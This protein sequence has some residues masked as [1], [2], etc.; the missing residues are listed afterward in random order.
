MV[1]TLAER[2]RR[3][4]LLIL[5]GAMGTELD[6]RGV[7]F[8]KGAWSGP[9]VLTHPDVVREIHADYARAGAEVHIA[10]SFATS[11]HVLAL[12]G[13]DDRF[14][15]ANR[16]AVDLC[17]QGIT[18]DG[19][20]RPQWI[21]GSVSTYAE[22]SKRTALPP[23]AQLR[24]NLRDQCKVLADAGVD[25]LA[26]EMLMDIEVSVML[27][28]AAAETGLPFWAGFT[29][30]W[31]DDG[32]VMAGAGGYRGGNAV[33]LANALDAV[34][35]AAD[36]APMMMSVM[37]CELDV[38][39]AALKVVGQKWTGDIVV[40]PNSGRYL[41]PSWDFSM[42]C[43]PEAFTDAAGRWAADG[44]RI[45]GGCCGLGPVHIQA[46]AAEFSPA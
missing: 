36:G 39:A 14:D 45:I 18:G 17:R 4:E 27:V 11:R 13:M 40:Y 21:A 19:I 7:V 44:A 22:S 28:E 35:A 12:A 9:A 43:T 41:N 42:V 25:A 20:D 32:Q 33:P 15:E 29:C 38:T 30:N 8:E 26:L 2:L 6:R 23:P 46:L 37:H 31:G 1:E 10:N 16:A 24:R 34:T 3:P 5:D